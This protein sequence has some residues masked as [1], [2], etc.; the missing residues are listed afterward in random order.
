MLKRLVAISA[1]LACLS[2]AACGN[3][4]GES[5]TDPTTEETTS[6]TTS[7][8]PAETESAAGACEYVEGGSPA[9]REVELPPSE[10]TVSGEVKVVFQ[11]TLGDIPATLDADATPCTVNSFVSLAEQGF[12]DDSPC[13][14]MATAPSFGILQ[15][16]DPSGSGSGGPGYSYADELTGEETYEAGTLAMANAGPDTNGSQFFFVFNDSPGLTPDYNVFGSVDPAGLKLLT[17]AAKKGD[18]GSHPAGGGVPNAGPIDI[19]GVTIG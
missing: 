13:P 11:T 17:K 10:P 9:V 6:E 18:D 7:E 1:T 16:G 19:T 2:L 15:C 14:R 8:T 3:E 4:G 12:F 5:A